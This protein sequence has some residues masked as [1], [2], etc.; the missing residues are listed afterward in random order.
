MVADE[1]DAAHLW[2][3]LSA[4]RAALSYLQGLSKAQAIGDEMRM[5]AFERKLEIVGEA[6]RR[7]S[8]ACTQ[9]TPQIPWRGVIGL[10]NVLA[11]NYGQ[12]DRER[13]YDTAQRELPALIAALEAA[14]P[15]G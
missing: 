2:D 15:D 3:M 13:L 6:A 12:I 1:R 9:A 5:A 11:H 14:L 4:A 8:T 7:V 10:R